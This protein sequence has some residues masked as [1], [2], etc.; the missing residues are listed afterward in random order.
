MTVQWAVPAE[1]KV[2]PD[3]LQVRLD[4]YKDSVLLYLHAEDGKV[5]TKMVSARD[6]AQAML[7]ELRLSSGVLP[8]D[9]LW[10]SYGKQWSE[11]ALWRY[12]QVWS[13][14]IV[15]KP[16]EPPVRLKIPMPGLVFV[17]SPCQPPKVVAAKHRPKAASDLIYHA[18][19]FNTYEDGR[20]CP[21]SHKYPG[22]VDEIPESFF[23]AFFS[24][25]GVS[26]NR[27]K[28]HP[29]SLFAWWQEIDGHE[30]YPLGDL[31]EMG[32]VEKLMR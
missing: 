32:K 16:A 23:Q 4:F 30:R 12:P 28:S 6:V 7:S 22:E 10:W 9:T 5:T 21:G 26:R 17:C 27:S 14:A 13:V 1:L 3:K 29:D 8:P 11:V 2:P 31:I 24:I 19:L 25:D 15:L 20:T 18:P